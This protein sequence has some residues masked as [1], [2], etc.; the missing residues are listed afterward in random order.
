MEGLESHV[1]GIE[2][3]RMRRAQQLP[4]VRTE[5]QSVSPLPPSYIAVNEPAVVLMQAI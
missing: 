5:K 1:T 4:A 2:C 3:G